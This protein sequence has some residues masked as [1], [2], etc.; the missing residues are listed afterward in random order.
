LRCET[1][2]IPDVK[3]IVPTRHGDARGYFVESYNQRALEAAGIADVFIQDDESLSTAIGTVRG[4]HC[5]T[6]PMQQ[7]KLVRVLRGRILDIVVDLR[8]G[9]P[10]FGQHVAAEL[11]AERG[12]QL[13][14]PRGFAHGFCTLTEE[15]VVFY[16]KTAYWNRDLEVGILWND[17]ALALPWPVSA[18]NAI[19]S[20]KDRLLPTLADLPRH[21]EYERVTA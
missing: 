6:A 17:P 20:D 11:T 9:S 4:L 2:A 13:Y 8:H 15:T 5:Q 14:V 16:K 10:W 1:L 7:A 21:F 19:V 18:E 3:L 12:E